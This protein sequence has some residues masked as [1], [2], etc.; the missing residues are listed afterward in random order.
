MRTTLD[1]RAAYHRIHV[2]L[3]LTQGA[4]CPRMCCNTAR[5]D[6]QTTT[7]QEQINDR[8]HHRRHPRRQPFHP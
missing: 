3:H 2:D 7:S 6:H 4:V 1:H 8:H 5:S